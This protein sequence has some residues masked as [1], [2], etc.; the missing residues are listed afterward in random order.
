[1]PILIEKHKYPGTTY[2]AI[3]DKY[4]FHFPRPT[5]KIFDKIGKIFNKDFTV[6]YQ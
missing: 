4:F 2:D 3:S 6:A 1:M 5:K